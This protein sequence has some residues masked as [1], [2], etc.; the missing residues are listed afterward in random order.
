M[1]FILLDTYIKN[2]SLKYN[3]P[4]LK[5]TCKKYDLKISGEKK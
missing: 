1:I 2:Q 3:L 4:V 5:N